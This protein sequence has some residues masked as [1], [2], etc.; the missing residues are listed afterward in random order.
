MSGLRA[1]LVPSPLGLAERA[2]PAAAI[3]IAAAG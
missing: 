2:M 1:N 3:A